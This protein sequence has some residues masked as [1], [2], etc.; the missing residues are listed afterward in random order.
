V[1]GWNTDKPALGD[2][3][4]MRQTQNSKAVAQFVA[5]ELRSK[6]PQDDHFKFVLNRRYL[7]WVKNRRYPPSPAQYDRTTT[8][9]GL[10]YLKIRRV[11]EKSIRQ[12]VNCLFAVTQWV[13]CF[14]M[15]HNQSI[16]Q[17]IYRCQLN[18]Y[19]HCCLLQKGTLDVTLHT[20]NIHACLED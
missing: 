9:K 3:E 4:K 17:F 6:Q 16:N 8:N 2:N 10:Y 11:R 13:Y 14:S 1:N 5:E 12:L 15:G 18:D 19:S 7:Y 20:W